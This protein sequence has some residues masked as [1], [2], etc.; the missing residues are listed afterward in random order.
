VLVATTFLVVSLA[1]VAQVFA[2]ATHAG[3]RAKQTT[4]AT[5]LAQRK[6][7]ELVLDA[8]N[9]AGSDFIDARGNVVAGDS[10]TASDAVYLRR[11]FIDP[12]PASPA[13]TLVVQVLV[14]SA[15]ARGVGTPAAHVL[16]PGEA[17]LVTLR[18][19]KAP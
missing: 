11:W 17:A 2:G 9:G 18:P 4:F 14:T 5:V 15:H 19:R 3:H 6:M 12:L 10:T 7:E 8:A 13:D 16:L 1:T